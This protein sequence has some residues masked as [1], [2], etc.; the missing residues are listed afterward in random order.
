MG[1]VF[2]AG[3]DD[4][5]CAR[6]MQSFWSPAATEGGEVISLAGFR[7]TRNDES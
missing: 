5:A 3:H 6:V 4:P 1:Q 7:R 2:A